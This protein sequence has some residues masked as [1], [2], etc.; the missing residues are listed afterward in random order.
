ML[1]LASRQNSA[2]WEWLRDDPDSVSASDV[3]KVVFA[4]PFKSRRKFYQEKKKGVKSEPDFNP[5]SWAIK[6]AGH[7]NEER[8]FQMYIDWNHIPGRFYRQPGTVSRPDKFRIR[9]SPDMFEF[10]EH[11]NLIRGVEFKSPVMRDLPTIPARIYHE[12]IIQCIAC[13]IVIRGL[14]CQWHSWRLVYTKPIEEDPTLIIYDIGCDK[15][16]A[17]SLY[18]KVRVFMEETDST[19]GLRNKNEEDKKWVNSWLKQINIVRIV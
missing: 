14:D 9:C 6:E 19:Q 3:A 17:V 2:L 15:K 7:R 16:T 13:S 18:E 1:G 4:D 10:D 11:Q 5:F 8:A 12:H